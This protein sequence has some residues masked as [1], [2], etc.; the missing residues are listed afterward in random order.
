MTPTNYAHSCADISSHK[1]ETVIGREFFPLCSA[2]DRSWTSLVETRYS[3]GKRTIGELFRDIVEDTFWATS[4]DQVP[5]DWG[6]ITIKDQSV[7]E[8]L[9]KKIIKPYKYN[10]SRLVS[11]NKTGKGRGNVIPMCQMA[12][13]QSENRINVV[14]EYKDRHQNNYDS[15]EAKRSVHKVEAIIKETI[16]LENE[17]KLFEHST[18][19]KTL[20]WIDAYDELSQ[21]DMTHCFLPM[22][23][24]FKKKCNHFK[25]NVDDWYS[26]MNASKDFLVLCHMKIEMKYFY[27]SAISICSNE[28]DIDIMMV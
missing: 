17:G 16:R 25:S 26:M 5:M 9:G 13:D 10:E 12:K 27:K 3:D 23:S 8:I 4:G 22:T 1:G 21:E 2:F 18:Q 6:D 24:F 7:A 14:D 28:E 20:S 11:H 19:E 15:I